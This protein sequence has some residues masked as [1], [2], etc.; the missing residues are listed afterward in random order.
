MHNSNELLKFK[1][2]L[3]LFLSTFL[4]Q[5]RNTA[6]TPVNLPKN[7]TIPAI[8]VFG[9]S[10]VDTGN[11]NYLETIVKVNYPPYGQDFVGGR[12]T[13]R[14]CDG[15][16]PS[17]LIAEELGIKELVPAYLDP[18]LQ[19]QDLL[20]GVNFASGGSGFDPLT[21]NV[22][23]VLSLSDQL[24]MFKDY[25]TKLEHIIGQ[26]KTSALLSE[27]LFTVVSGS[28]DITN[29][30]FGTVSL[31]RSQFDVSAYTDLLVSYAS[32]FVQDVYKLGGRRM[33]V[34]GLAPLGCLPSQRSLEGGV[35]RKCVNLYNQ[36]AEM[37][38]H[39]LSVQLSSLSARYLDATLVYVDIYRLP[40]DLIRLP[41]KYGFQVSDKGCCGTGTIEVAFLCKYTCGN[42]SEY[43]FWDS[44]HLTE[45][46]Y[47]L[48]VHDILTTSIN[49]FVS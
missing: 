41:L 47:R 33:G 1:P 36:V 46:A 49:N 27:A 37:F 6:E 8:V 34:F 14:F 20:T 16:V 38:N 42:A 39:K 2:L 18:N 48:L 4:F 22:V 24:E 31:R 19:P 7:I 32:A 28:N 40:L 15:K 44:F 9:D 21:S 25:I 10:V 12:P 26:Q 13:G 43:V 29:T 45:N 30:Y 17:D 3:F 23:S 35:E 5:H 11:N